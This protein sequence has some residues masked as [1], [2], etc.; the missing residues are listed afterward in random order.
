M[1]VGKCELAYRRLFHIDYLGSIR[2][3]G[4]VRSGEI[5]VLSRADAAIS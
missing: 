4:S 5:R 3:L 2:G 1:N